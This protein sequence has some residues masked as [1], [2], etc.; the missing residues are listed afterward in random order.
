MTKWI[1]IGKIIVRGVQCVMLNVVLFIGLCIYWWINNQR[2][3]T[4][5]LHVTVY[6]MTIFQLPQPICVLHE[7]QQQQPKNKR[8][9]IIW[10]KFGACPL[11]FPFFLFFFFFVLAHTHTQ[12]LHGTLICFR[13]ENRCERN[14]KIIVGRN[15]LF[16]L[17]LLLIQFFGFRSIQIVS[18]F[19]FF[20]SVFVLLYFFLSL[21]LHHNCLLCVV[22]F[23]I[24]FII[25][26][27]FIMIRVHFLLETK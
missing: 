16:I 8:C 19:F 13:S 11:Y 23:Q 10:K 21:L 15:N 2:I 12:Y 6:F 7:Q 5:S 1:W 24:Y 27:F 18:K 9:H 3:H 22:Y 25:R 4:K 14:K 20:R 26:F 17:L